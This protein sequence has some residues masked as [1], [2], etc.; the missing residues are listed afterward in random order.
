LAQG[1]DGD[2]VQAVASSGR[3]EH[4]IRIMKLGIVSIFLPEKSGIAI[5][6]NNLVDH[7]RGVN[8]L[9]IVT[10]GTLKSNADYRIKLDSLGLFKN[11]N[12]I[13][14]K[15]SLEIIHFQYNASLY[16]KYTL[17]FPILRALKR[18]RAPKIVT[19]HEVQLGSQTV[20][21]KILSSIE[22]KIV[23]Y[24][25][26]II[27]HSGNQAEL[28]NKQYRTKKAE[29]IYHG[30]EVK[31][32]IPKKGKNILFFGMISEGKGVTYLIKSMDYLKGY[33]LKIAG[34]PITEKYKNKILEEKEKTK[35]CKAIELEL[36]WVTEKE[37]DLLYRWA[38]IVV[39]PYTWAPY[40]SG[41]LHDA[42]SYGIPAVVTRVGAIWEIVEKFHLGI[43]V[44]PEKPAGLAE[45]IEQV[46]NNYNSYKCG[47]LIY[48]NE[49]NWKTTG[50]NH[51]KL[52]SSI[53]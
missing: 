47:I 11:L 38:S 17:N 29:C 8:D 34:M 20:K 25:N 48:S 52:Y 30:M 10:I 37:K 19:L 3:R 12:K 50:S 24:A 14:E 53:V 2:E 33:K 13:I 31:I 21:E 40:Q 36:G 49:A 18:I 7:M 9:E 42:L 44:E 1:K 6:S 15:E 28:I 16:G 51:I 45:G 27:T 41:V 22:N 39:L 4:R 35:N 43:T 26:R 32:N 5:Y 23:G 46:Y